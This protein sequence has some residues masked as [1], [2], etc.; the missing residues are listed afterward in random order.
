ME[1]QAG[2]ERRHS[3]SCIS[4][5]V[6]CVQ[7]H[8][9]CVGVGR[10]WV[11]Q[12]MVDGSHFSH[13]SLK[14]GRKSFRIRWHHL[15]FLF[16]LFTV[17]VIA[18]SLRVHDETLRSFSQLIAETYAL[19]EQSKWFQLAE[20]RIL[21]LN[22][23]GN[24]LFRVEST[25]EYEEQV[26]HFDTAMRNMTAVLDGAGRL[27]LD[28]EALRAEVAG[29]VEPAQELIDIFAPLADRDIDS[30]SRHTMF[31]RGGPVMARMDN[32]QHAALRALGRLSAQNAAGRHH[33]LHQHEAALQSRIALQRYFIAAVVVILFGM[34][35][36]GRRIQQTQLALEAERRQVAEER[37][38]RLAAIGELCSSVAH[39]IRNPLAAIRSSAELTLE[40]G[41]MDML[42][43]ERMQ[44]IL[45]EGKRLGDRVNGLL[46]IAK[47]SQEEFKP[48]CLND[49][50][51]AASRDLQAAAADR[52]IR[53]DCT[54]PQQRL[55]TRGDR[56]RLEQ[57]V[58][59]LLSNAMD[60]SQP[61]DSIGMALSGPDDG[62][63][64]TISVTDRG[65]GVPDA[66]RE[67]IFDLFF[68]TKPSGTGIGLATVKRVSKLHGGEIDLD[69]RCT[70]GAKFCLRL[71]LCRD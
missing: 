13:Q 67:N 38:E 24:D 47:A 68:T 8:I 12:I 48:V 53:I 50:L 58:I 42:S 9:L 32:A 22:A 64:A 52:G 40:L 37:R 49:V 6:V 35:V 11:R 4:T 23:P 69:L 71:P 63:V 62:D 56:A 34:F 33:L 10:L 3:N 59:E 45:A 25:D 31:V 44:D 54:T 66:I 61:G 1:G 7:C 55:S 5:H 21:E 30:E 65:P 36:F 17:V 28:A 43:R 20:Q 70:T 14:S 29:I 51:L 16:A 2:S 39:G 18:F 60:H 26:R 15:Y 46:N 41:E 19:D 57:A 27:G